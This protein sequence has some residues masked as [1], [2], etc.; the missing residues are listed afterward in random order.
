MARLVTLTALCGIVPYVALQLRSIGIAIALLS[1]RDVAGPVM[2]VA[3][4]G[5]GLFAILFGARR[6]EVAGRTEGLMFS[7]AL[8]STIKLVAL[9]IIA[10]VSL[11]VLA[12]AP[13]LRVQQSLALLGEHFRPAAFSIDFGVILLVSAL[14]VVVLPRQ[15]FMGLAQARDPHDL[16]RARFGLAAYIATMAAMILPIALAGLLRCRAMPCP[17]CSCCAFPLLVT[18]AGR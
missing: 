14:A 7:I 18:W 2:I 10:G 3:A 16:H 5:L 13:A 1:S 17:I 4:V 6:Y 9:V 11:R 15:F 12:D 8:E